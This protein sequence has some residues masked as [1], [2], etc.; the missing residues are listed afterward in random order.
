MATLDIICPTINA[1]RCFLERRNRLPR[2]KNRGALPHRL[3]DACQSLFR[4]AFLGDKWPAIDFFVELLGVSAKRPY[5]HVQVKSTT[6]PLPTSARSLKISCP[7]RDVTRLLEIPGPT[8]LLG[9][10]EPT[11]R[12]FAKSIHLGVAPKAVRRIE[13]VNELHPANLQC[14]HDEVQAYWRSVGHKPS[15]SVFA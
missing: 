3:F 14:L 1:D 13:S 7:K 5:F 4:L 2:G 6:A 8:Y 9:V 15:T 12:V 10:H 11:R